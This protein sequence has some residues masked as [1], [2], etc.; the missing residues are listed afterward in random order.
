MTAREAHVCRSTWNEAA[1]SIFAR[2]QASVIGRAWCAAFQGVPSAFDSKMAIPRLS[3]CERFEQCRA[4]VVE[5]DMAA[6]AALAGSDVDRPTIRVEIR[7][8][9]RSQ[10][11]IPCASYKRGLR[12]APEIGITGIQE[13]FCLGDGEIPHTG[14]VGFLE[15][16]NATPSF[17]GR[18]FAF[19]PRAIERGF[20]NRQVFGLR[21]PDGGG[22]HRHRFC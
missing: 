4:L 2:L 19:S 21:S 22:W 15:W 12:Q 5:N 16:L 20:Q 14:G 10:F 11:A 8:P 7:R 17:I 13:P 6:F 9:K 18:N 3:C 1:G